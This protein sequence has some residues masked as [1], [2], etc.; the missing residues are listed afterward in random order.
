MKGMAC[1]HNILDST[2]LSL[3]TEALSYLCVRSFSVEFCGM[4]SVSFSIVLIDFG[5]CQVMESPQLLHNFS[6]CFIATCVVSSK[7]MVT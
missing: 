2:S 4:P 6:S 7:K 1:I 5:T 3:T